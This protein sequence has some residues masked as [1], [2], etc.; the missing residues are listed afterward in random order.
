GRLPR[1]ARRSSH[2]PA[3]G[4]ERGDTRRRRARRHR[5]LP[6]AVRW[7]RRPARGGPHGARPGVL[8]RRHHPQPHPHPHLGGDPDGGRNHRG[9]Q[10]HILVPRPPRAG[11]TNTI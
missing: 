4:G 8:R 5:R 7:S 6:R 2:V 1:R 11:G 3:A 9:A 10:A